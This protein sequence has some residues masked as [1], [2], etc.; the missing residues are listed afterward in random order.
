MG[1]SA[2]ILASALALSACSSGGSSSSASST[3]GDGKVELTLWGTYG[4]GGNSAQS[5]ALE[6]EIIPAFEKANPDIK[7]TY[8]DMPYDGLKQK[9]TTGAAAGELPDLIRTDLGWNAQFAKLGVLQQLDGKMPNYDQ[10]AARVYPGLL[11]TTLYNG[12]HYGLPLDTN[13]RVM[14]TNPDALKKAGVEKAPATFEEMREFAKKFEG[15]GVYAFAEGGISQWS[16]LPWVWSAGG[17]ITDKDHTKASGYL[18]SDKS[19]AG[20]QLLVDLYQA[21]QIPNLMTGNKGATETSDG[22]P[23]GQY[24]SIL[25]GPWMKEIWAK[26]YPNFAP[27]YTAMPAGEGGSISVVGGESIVITN[28]VKNLEAAYKFVEFTQSKEFQ[29][30]MSKAGQMTVVQEFA[31]EEASATPFYK[32][33]SEQLKTAKARLSIPDAGKVD[34]ILNAELTP[35]FEGKVSVKEAL[36]KAASQIDPLLTK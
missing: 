26:Q 15:S 1:V 11:D 19:V 36:T 4:A 14:V 18:N 17:D 22:V 9:L 29:L 13:T 3:S 21:G 23:G 20:V 10:L 28:K 32:I 34:D 8:V 27:D 24:A 25:D 30:P 12:H 7:I 2:A 6:K 33:F 5:D 31:A 35:A 16:I